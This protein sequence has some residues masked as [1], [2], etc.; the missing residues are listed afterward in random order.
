M[1]VCLYVCMSV[2]LYVCMSVRL[3][4]CTSVCLCVCVSVCLYVCM[5]VC[6]CVCMSAFY[7]CGLSVSVFL[8]CCFCLRG[9]GRSFVVERLFAMGRCWAM[10]EK[11]GLCSCTVDMVHSR[12]EIGRAVRLQRAREEAQHSDLSQCCEARGQISRQH[13]AR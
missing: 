10:H 11:E 13:R 1:S 12:R 6:L 9:C 3:Y 2:C 4:V 7:V 5:S 8:V